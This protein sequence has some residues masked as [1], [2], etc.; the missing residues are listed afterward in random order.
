MKKILIK[1]N[2]ILLMSS[3]VVPSLT[4]AQSFSM[5][6][7][8]EA[9]SNLYAEKQYNRSAGQRLSFSPNYELA[10]NWQTSGTLT[11]SQDTVSPARTTLE[12]TSLSLSYTGYKL[13]IFDLKNKLLGTLPTR[14]ESWDSEKYKGSLGFGTDLSIASQYGIL[15][16]SATLGL[17]GHRN[18]HEF[19]QNAEGSPN[20]QNSL[21][22][23]LA[24]GWQLTSNL[25]FGVFAAYRLARTY[26]ESIRNSFISS[27]NLAYSLSKKLNIYGGTSLGERAAFKSNGSDS[28]ISLFDDNHSEIFAGLTYIL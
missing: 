28:N 9:G 5:A 15:P 18:F 24:F 27:A 17:S 7:Q 13:G 6:T 12:N 10:K 22:T 3:L 16:N 4:L 1:S 20:I 25:N 2:L 8:I 14:Q 11:I 19:T 26:E 23:S 21:R